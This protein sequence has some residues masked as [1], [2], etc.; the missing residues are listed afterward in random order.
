[1]SNTAVQAQLF[2]QVTSTWTEITSILNL[3]SPP[4]EVDSLKATVLAST[5]HEYLPG[6]VD[7]G[8]L[9]AEIIYTAT[10]Y[11]VINGLRGS[12]VPW[13]IVFK[14]GMDVTFSG[15]VSS[16]ECKFDPEELQT[17]SF[18]VKVTGALTIVPPS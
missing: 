12:V 10:Q 6:L 4:G 18:K 8:E 13:K 5:A 3:D 15:F 17:V 14:D 9:S 1:M 11:Q 16:C 7:P 2:H